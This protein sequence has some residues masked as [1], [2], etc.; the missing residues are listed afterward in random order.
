MQTPRGATTGRTK[1]RRRIALLGERRESFLELDT[2]ILL[3]AC[4]SARSAARFLEER[5][6]PLTLLLD[7]SRAVARGYG[8]H[9]RFTLPR[10]NIARPASFLIDRCGFLRHAYVA[11]L[12]I[13][14][15]PIEEL[16]AAARSLAPPRARPEQAAD[17]PGA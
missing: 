1:P 14:A 7:E 15:A 6:T 8:V 9:Q 5:P 2:R 13:H 11:R 17:A 10:W 3:V 16:L 12:P 4:E